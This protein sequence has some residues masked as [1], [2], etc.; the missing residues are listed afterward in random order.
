MTLVWIV[1]V[2]TV[3]CKLSAYEIPSICPLTFG[4]PFV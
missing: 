4:L 3:S 2:N 1:S